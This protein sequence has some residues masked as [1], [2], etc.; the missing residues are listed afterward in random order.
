MLYSH[1]V[2]ASSGGGI[3][4]VRIILSFVF[5]TEK[6]GEKLVMTAVELGKVNKWDEGAN[7]YGGQCVCEED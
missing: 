6:A 2:S 7:E 4:L 3:K 5:P 1:A